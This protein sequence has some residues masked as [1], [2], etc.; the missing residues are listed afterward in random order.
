MEVFFLKQGAG[1]LTPIMHGRKGWR[2]E[3]RHAME[4]DIERE[5]ERARLCVCTHE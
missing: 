4:R 2:E 3:E 1:R 5:S